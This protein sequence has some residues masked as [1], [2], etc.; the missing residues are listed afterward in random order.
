MFLSNVTPSS[1]NLKNFNTNTKKISKTTKQNY[2]GWGHNY[3]NEVHQSGEHV[4]KP[5][6]IN[7][8]ILL[9]PMTQMAESGQG[10]QKSEQHAKSEQEDTV[11][12]D[13]LEKV[14]KEKQ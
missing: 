10:Q 9:I 3:A 1:A 12:K 5:P 7:R 8:N 13:P 6:I 2:G 14:C 4:G 11:L